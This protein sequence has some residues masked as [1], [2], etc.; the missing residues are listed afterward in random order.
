VGGSRR[1]AK[2]KRVGKITL[3]SELAF[4]PFFDFAPALWAKVEVAFDGESS[5]SFD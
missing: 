1:T 5:R 2:Q 3:L 4:V